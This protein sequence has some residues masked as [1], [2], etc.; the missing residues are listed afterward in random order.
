MQ[1]GG[2]REGYTGYP[3]RTSELSLF[4]VLA[5]LTGSYG[6]LTGNILN[7]LRSESLGSEG[8]LGAVLRLSLDQSEV[9]LRLVQTGSKIDL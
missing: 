1:T 5:S 6:R 3:A 7:I 2:Y 9:A 4:E 8:R